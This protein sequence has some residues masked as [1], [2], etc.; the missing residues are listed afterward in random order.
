MAQSRGGGLSQRHLGEAIARIDLEQ[1]DPGFMH[2][3]LGRR[4]RPSRLKGC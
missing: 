1:P 4:R 2:D 3:R